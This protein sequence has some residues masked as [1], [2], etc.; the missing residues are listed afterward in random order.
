MALNLPKLISNAVAI[1]DDATK[2][3]QVSVT[4]RAWISDSDQWGN[5][6]Y[7]SPLTLRALY[8]SKHESKLD[9]NTGQVV[10]VQGKLTILDVPD[11]NGATGRVEPIDNR[12]L[13]VLPDGTTG[14]IFKPEGLYNPVAGKPFLIELWI[15]V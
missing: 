2:S 8:E 1:A 12:D 6:E 11:P 15:G 9:T 14:P 5:K 4:Y 13:I 3:I 10:Q 7:A